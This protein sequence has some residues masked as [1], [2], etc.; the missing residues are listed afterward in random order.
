ML[1]ETKTISV[2]AIDRDACVNPFTNFFVIQ[3]DLLRKHIKI[4][5]FTVSG[6]EMV[7]FPLQL[8]KKSFERERTQ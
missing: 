7:K 1:F 5:Q 3:F 6:K 8:S 4:V 2:K